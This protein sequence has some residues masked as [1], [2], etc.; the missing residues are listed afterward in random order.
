MADDART[1]GGTAMGV[2]VTGTGLVGVA[3]FLPT[4]YNTYLSLASPVMTAIFV[5]LWPRIMLRIEAGSDLRDIKRAEKFVENLGMDPAR[6]KKAQAT[7][8]KIKGDMAA[9]MM[10]RLESQNPKQGVRNR[11]PSARVKAAAEEPGT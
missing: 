6:Q 4:P 2:G 9:K 11:K 8:N 3:Q 1:S 7:L 10:V 5:W